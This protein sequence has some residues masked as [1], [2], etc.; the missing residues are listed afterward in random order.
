MKQIVKT[1]V[2]ALLICVIH[3]SVVFAN[4]KK[5]SVGGGGTKGFSFS[6]FSD[7][8]CTISAIY[9]KASSHLGVA[10][11]L[12]SGDLV[13]AGISSQSSYQSC[14]AGLPSGT[15]VFIVTSLQGGSPFRVVVNCTDQQNINAAGATS[16]GGIEIREIEIG[17]AENYLLDQFH[18]LAGKSRQTK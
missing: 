17:A 16:R 15:F 6:T 12:T 7:G 4:M 10:M 9:D 18:D 5:S 1:F 11:G 8:F 3:N 2:V 13:C 14:T